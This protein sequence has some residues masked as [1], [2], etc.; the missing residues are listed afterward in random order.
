VSITPESVKKLLNSEDLGDRL[1]GVNHLRE[2][3]ADV[4]FE[5]IQTP[6]FDS[7]PRVRYAA[8]SQVSTLGRQN[9]T[10]AL[11]IL[12]DR[13]LHDEEADVKAAAADALGALQMTDTLDDLRTLYHNSSDWIVQMSIIAALGEM[14]D[15]RAFDLL[16]EALRS[17]EPLIQTSAVGS[18]GELG[19]ER[20]IDLLAEQAHNEDWQVRY[21]LVQALG[22]FH[23][24]RVRQILETL[25]EDEIEQVAAEA[26]TRLATL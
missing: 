16:A 18:L 20:A 21:R 9:P 5:A 24:E 10:K 12:R 1:R 6:I 3:D 15:A 7:N 14:G 13:L 23:E 17:P 2:L 4:A 25:A 26:Q 22:N 19:D 8:V 11:E